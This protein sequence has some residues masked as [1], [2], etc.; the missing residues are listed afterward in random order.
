M[1][2]VL[3]STLAIPTINYVAILPELILFGGALGMLA[4]VA[5]IRREFAQTTYAGITMAIGTA[6]LVAALFLW[7]DVHK[8]GAFQTIAQSVNADGFAVFV[9]VL[10]SAVLVVA[11]TFATDY[12]AGEGVR[13]AEYYILAL[14]SGGGAILMGTANDLI[15]VFLAL[16][17]LSIPL[18][19][20]AGL[21]ARRSRS[22][23]AAMKYFLL[24]SFSSAIFVYGVALIYGAT[25]ATNIGSIAAFLSRNVLTSPGTLYAGG[26]L[27]LIGFGFKIAAVPFH[28]WSPDVYEGAPD[29][30]VGFMATIAKIG[31]FAAFL[32]VFLSAL[33]TL[34]TVWQPVVWALSVLSLV[35]GAVI[36][37]SQQNVKRMLAYSSIN[38]AGFV[39]LGLVAATSSG[40]SSSLY[41]LFTYSFVVLGS[42]GVV[43]YVAQ[44]R[45]QGS[46]LNS[47]RGLSRRSPA[48]A[49]LFAV[50][51]LAQAG[52]PFTTGFF[53]K[54]YVLSAVIGVHSYAIAVVAMASAAV[55]VF[56]YLR[57]VLAM[58]GGSDDAVLRTGLIEVS[59]WGWTA[60][61]TCALATFAFG[62]WPAPLIDFAR[63]ASL[64]IH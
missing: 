64:L 35:L 63:S 61:G 51:L 17:I 14:I 22:G 44:H 10:V 24:G 9:M 13:G 58:Y 60:L 27:L 1:N 15:L 5:V 48:L 47:F 52:A 29:G 34:T 40:I 39:L 37:L 57:I 7:H 12:L 25:G 4:L 56:F 46:E 55:S 38:H 20:I 36:A 31:G 54:F 19:V 33:S 18:Y 32:R 62:V 2:A 53:A 21:N 3:A 43:S 11:P 49:A 59:R 23:E 45:E 8:G 28:M 41:Y 16:E 6:S 26:A 50:F 30:V 42:F